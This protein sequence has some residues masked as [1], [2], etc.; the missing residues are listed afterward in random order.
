MNQ[1]F[2][3]Q[4]SEENVRQTSL[5]FYRDF[6]LNAEETTEELPD[7]RALQEKITQVIGQLLRSEPERL[8]NLMY[9]LDIDETKLK[10]VFDHAE[11]E[12]L[13]SQLAVL[14]LERER[15]KVYWRNKY[16]Q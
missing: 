2:D 4:P 5:L 15:Q 16:R 11:E 8:M 7:F 1:P 9:R 12:S 13:P 14:V 3:Q 6:G 10:F